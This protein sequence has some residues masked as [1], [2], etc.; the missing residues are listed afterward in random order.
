MN[1][2]G[3]RGY[4]KELERRVKVLESEKVKMEAELNKHKTEREQA[5]LKAFNDLENEKKR[6]E[7]EL[8]RQQQVHEDI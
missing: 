8:N 3:D 5:S 1:T 6:L 4:K 7:E 2:Q